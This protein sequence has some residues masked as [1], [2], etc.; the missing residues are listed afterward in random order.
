MGAV[1]ATR[2]ISTMMNDLL[3]LIGTDY[4]FSVKSS[5]TFL[6]YLPGHGC[7]LKSHQ[8]RSVGTFKEK[9]IRR[10]V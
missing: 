9:C 1:V 6:P 10:D 3:N 5:N 8:P 2:L 7:Q 4:V